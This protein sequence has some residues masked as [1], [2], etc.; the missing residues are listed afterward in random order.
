MIKKNETMTT[1]HYKKL[2]KNPTNCIKNKIY[3][4]LHE[5]REEFRGKYIIN[6]LFL[7]FTKNL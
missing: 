3:K 6:H 5:Y 4:M 7:W 1:G 2:N